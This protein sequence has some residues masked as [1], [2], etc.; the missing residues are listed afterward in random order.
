MSHKVIPYGK[1]FISEEDIQAVVEVLKS[2][3]L[4]QGPKIEE[5]EQKFAQ[6]IGVNYAVAVS[7]GTAALHLC[8]LALEVSPGQSWRYPS[9]CS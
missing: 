4:T 8:A 3:Y 6:Y 7:N 2:D 5:F 1:Q 9:A